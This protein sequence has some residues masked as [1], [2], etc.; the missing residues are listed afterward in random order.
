MEEVITQPDHASGP[1]ASAHSG[2]GIFQCL[3]SVLQD[4]DKDKR[5]SRLATD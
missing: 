2:L 3:S 1:E 5:I 4:S